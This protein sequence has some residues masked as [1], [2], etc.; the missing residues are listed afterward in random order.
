M[1]RLDIVKYLIEKGA[2]VNFKNSEGNTVLIAFILAT[3]PTNCNTKTSLEIVKYLIKNGADV[4]VTNANGKTAN[5]LVLS[6]NY[7]NNQNDL[8]SII[9]QAGG[10]KKCDI[11]FVLF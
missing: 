6:N 7:Y 11:N 2:D 3:Q 9:R 8:A 10:K 5:Q 1:M 4:N